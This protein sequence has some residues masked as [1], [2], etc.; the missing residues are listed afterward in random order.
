[1]NLTGF[2]RENGVGIRQHWLAVP[3]VGCVNRTVEL[4]AERAPRMALLTHQGGCGMLRDD[5]AQFRDTLAGMLLN[6]NVGGGVVVGLGCETNQAADIASLANRGPGAVTSLTLQAAGGVTSAAEAVCRLFDG[7][8][9]MVSRVQ[10][11]PRDLR[12]VVTVRDDAGPAGLAHA[13]HFATS[14]Q[15]YGFDVLGPIAA[16]RDTGPAT[17]GGS[18][19]GIW[20]RDDVTHAPSEVQA[21]SVAAAQGAV[22]GVAFAGEATPVGSPVMPVIRVTSAPGAVFAADCQLAG[23]PGETTEQLLRLFEEVVNG[24]QTFGESIG[25]R[26]FAPPRIAPTM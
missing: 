11:A 23:P 20:A 5:V 15:G 26:D 13:Q 6:P 18:V 17:T 9:A 3:S 12:V 10:V 24:R 22:I 8:D 25:Q 19:P 16:V 1:M 14:L 2:V 21:L 7:R 4:A